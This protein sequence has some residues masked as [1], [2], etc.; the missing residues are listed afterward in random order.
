LKQEYVS[1]A[2]VHDQAQ[3]ILD[4]Q[5]SPSFL[6]A[7]PKMGIMWLLQGRSFV[8]QCGNWDIA[9][10]PGW[11]CSVYHWYVM[12]EE[13]KNFRTSCIRSEYF[14]YFVLYNNVT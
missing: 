10:A 14:I 12:G 4:L 3:W 2:C 13:N 9:I 7:S 5:P 11:K 8:F 6:T 1:I